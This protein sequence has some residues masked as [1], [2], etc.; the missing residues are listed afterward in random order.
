MKGLIVCVFTITS[1]ATYAQETEERILYVVDSIPIISEPGEE[2]GTLTEND[3]ETLAVLTD[4]LDIEKHGYKDVD[5][6]IFIITKEY[7]RRPDELRKIPTVKQ[8]ERKN[9]RWYLKASSTPY[10]GQFIDYYFNGKK[11][12][13]GVLKAG[14]LEGLR[15]VYNPNGTTS[16]YEYYVGGIENGESK[17]YFQDGRLH[18]EGSYKNGKEDGLWKE[19]Y[20]T[21]QLKRQTE[22]KD[23]K[24]LSTKE[25]EKFH[26]LFSRGIELFNEGNY[27]GAIKSYDKAIEINPNYSDVYFHRSRAYLYDLKFDEAI[28]DCDK[29]IELEPMYKEAYSNRA[30]VRLRKHELKNSRTLSKGSGV[31]VLAAKDKV[32]I[33][34]DELEKICSDLSKAIQLGDNKAMILEAQKRYCQ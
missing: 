20:S 2:E 16:Y 15:T 17:E 1:L 34:E 26:S 9:G 24:I 18:Q 6:I 32:K 21:G 5:K 13:D 28:V 12:R 31:T 10:S 22:F 23:G 33:P 3:I 11:Q 14:V 19:W 4:K 8:M 30:F 29:A 7:A 25:D 27:A